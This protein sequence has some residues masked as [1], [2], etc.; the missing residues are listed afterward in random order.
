MAKE[1]DVELG[2]AQEQQH[3]SQDSTTDTH[4]QHTD[5]QTSDDNHAIDDNSTN[6]APLSSAQKTSPLESSPPITQEQDP[7]KGYW[8]QGRIGDIW[9][10]I[11]YF[12][13]SPIA[14]SRLM[15]MIDDS[16]YDELRLIESH[17]D[18]TRNVTAHTH[19]LT[20]E[21]KK[22]QAVKQP[23]ANTNPSADDVKKQ[24]QEKLDDF[25]RLK[26]QEA[27]SKIQEKMAMI[28]NNVI[29]KNDLAH[30]TITNHSQGDTPPQSGYMPQDPFA[31]LSPH[32]N[33]ANTKP[34]K[35]LS[36]VT[37]NIVMPA[38][39]AHKN[40]SDQNEHLENEI[41]ALA[42]L[43]TTTAENLPS[44]EQIQQENNA[45][46]IDD[47]V[48]DTA[49]FKHGLPNH[50]QQSQNDKQQAITPNPDNNVKD[51]QQYKQKKNKGNRIKEMTK[52]LIYGNDND[53]NHHH[54][55][56]LKNRGMMSGLV[57]GAVALT[58]A[59]GVAEPDIVQKAA[60]HI[61]DQASTLFGRSNLASAVHD[62]DIRAVRH[63]LADGAD[64]NMRDSDGKPV[65]I[66]S[67]EKGYID[68]F[69][70]LLAS[71][72]RSDDIVNKNE[73][74]VHYLAKK[75]LNV[76]LT[77]LLDHDI[78]QLDKLTSN[79]DPCL[80]PL[81]TA[82]GHQKQRAAMI[83]VSY[84]ADIDGR[85]DCRLTPLD[86]ASTDRAL[87]SRLEAL[88]LRMNNNSAP[89]KQAQKTNKTKPT[90][91]QIAKATK[92]E[93]PIIAIHNRAV[94]KAQ[95]V[96]K[97]QKT[98]VE[99]VRS[100]DNKRVDTLLSQKPPGINLQRVQIFVTTSWTTGY[101]S[102]AD[103]AILNNM[104]D[105][106]STLYH[107]GLSP[108]GDL[109]HF[110]IDEADKPEYQNL[111][112]YLL[113]LGVD[114]NVKKDG[115]TPLMRAAVRNLPNIV[116]VLLAGGSDPSIMSNEGETAAYFASL[117]GNVSLHESL[118]LA[119]HQDSFHELMLGVSWLDDIESLKEKII[120]CREVQ[121]FEICSLSLS[122]WLPDDS[123][124]LGHFDMRLEG[125]LV[126]LQ[127]NGPSLNQTSDIIDR[128]NRVAHAISLRYPDK[129]DTKLL[130]N[131]QASLVDK[132]LKKDKIDSK[133]LV[134]F[135]SDD[136]KKKPVYVQLKVTPL[137]DGGSYR[138]IIGNPFRAS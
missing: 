118:V 133:N 43:A 88:S 101:R 125:R 126:A 70:L 3:E 91:A 49:P 27:Q 59:F 44:L 20:V 26:Q 114:P 121:Q 2:S 136:N 117:S 23:V 81:M 22:V 42:Q 73:R 138:L 98:L 107:Y 28:R 53:P 72:A 40:H 66:V 75:G 74:L 31:D 124:V 65:T 63:A 19:I 18:K 45:V 129:T 38:L 12:K 130:T 16:H 84:G 103:Y 10:N 135:W 39:D 122:T 48:A 102:I 95:T 7:N 108:N 25:Y 111:V 97:Y 110:A 109:I 36:D 106:A 113:E 69:D 105:I 85:A 57:A 46:N 1:T 17:Y 96:E 93:N 83:L 86:L 34:K 87:A 21:G 123:V 62:N 99:A 41:Q 13:E 76:P 32:H 77:H 11:D 50:A 24:R 112:D 90:K 115:L 134:R 5:D 71:G 58:I 137:D 9:R 92:D 116:G 47:L 4:T 51:L 29:N 67:A 82:L 54:G 119:Q 33:N 128:F 56:Q 14:V 52:S 80:T 15:N 89:A 100:G 78:G 6:N 55:G 131:Q 37:A 79:N 104:R 30:D 8:I 64:P 94:A 68:I 35:Q 61:S 127:V 132:L 120:D 60:F